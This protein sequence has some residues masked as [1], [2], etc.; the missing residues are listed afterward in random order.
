MPSWG[1]RGLLCVLALIALASFGYGSASAERRNPPARAMAQ[2]VQ[3]YYEN[4]L[5][6]I[7]NLHA[8]RID[9]GVD[10]SGSGPMQSLGNG[11]ITA[12]YRGTSHF[13]AN[14]D[15]N[16]VVE[17][18][19]EGPLQGVSIYYAENCTPSRALFVGKDV[20][21]TTTLCR[22]HDEFPFLEVGFAQNDTSGIPAA[23]SAYR[24][25]PDGSKMAYGVDFSHLLGDLGAPGGNTNTGTGDLSY[26]V[27][28]T[29]GA[30]PP[31]FPRF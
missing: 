15:G 19:K 13:W 18:M 20:T 1:T 21:A 7:R 26:R 4:P 5:R 10:Y 16:V 17:R 8:K 27:D 9:E 23:W 24:T 6:L 12:I 3:R 25:V 11:R 14:V 31:G 2:A 22:L 29:V 28:T 30:L